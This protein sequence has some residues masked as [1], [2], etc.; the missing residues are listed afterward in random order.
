MTEVKIPV[1]LSR[2]ENVEVSNVQLN[3]NI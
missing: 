3:G 1:L 2:F